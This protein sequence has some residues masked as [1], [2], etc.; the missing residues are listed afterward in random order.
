MKFTERFNA[1][2]SRE[3]WAGGIHIRVPLVD[4]SAL[5]AQGADTLRGFAGTETE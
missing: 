3:L 2:D 1:K 4:L 5:V